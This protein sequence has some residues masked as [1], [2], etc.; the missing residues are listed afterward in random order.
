MHNNKFYLALNHGQGHVILQLHP[1]HSKEICWEIRVKLTMDLEH[2]FDL[3][4]GCDIFSVLDFLFSEIVGGRE[5][6]IKS[7]KKKEKKID[8]RHFFK[9]FTKKLNSP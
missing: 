4:L 8:Y 2:S 7:K 6:K 9:N 1:S 5:V 3:C